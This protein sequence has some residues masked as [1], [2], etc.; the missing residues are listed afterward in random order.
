MFESFLKRTAFALALALACV[1]AASAGDS[2]APTNS[3]SDKSSDTTHDSIRA[4]LKSG[5][6]AA[7][8]E[9]QLLNFYAPRNFRPAWSGNDD[10]VAEAASVKATIAKADLQGLHA[11]DYTA[12]LAR[13]KSGRPRSGKDAAAYDVALTTALFHYASDVRTGR[14]R[15]GDAYRDVD[16]PPRF[17]DPAS[18]LTAALRDDKLGAFLQALPP[19][20]PGYRYLAEVYA[21][22]RAVAAAGGW[23][24]VPAGTTF[25]RHD[26]KI[27]VLGKRLALE[28]PTLAANAKPSSGD[29]HEAL[30]RY[31]KRNAL[32]DDGKLGPEVLKSLN[33]P[34]GA[35]ADQIA[36]NMDRWRW[37][38]RY[39]EGRY[40]E[41]DVPDQSVTFIQDGS[42]ELYSPVI[43]GKASTPTPILRTTVQTVVANPSW[44]IPVDIAARKLLPKLRQK[45][46]YLLARHMV[47]AGGPAD[48][49]HGTKIDWKHVTAA[50]LRYQIQ[51]DP[52]NDNAL[53]TI[54]FDMPNNFDVYLHDTPEKK[55][56][57]LAVREKSNGCVRVQKIADLASLVLKGDDSDAADDLEPAI[58]SG[59]TQRFKLSDPV[60]VYMVYWTAIA[61]PDGTVH[62][63]P[64]LYGRDR[65]L[66][67]KL[68]SARSAAS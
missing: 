12:A 6:V 59:Q 53:G 52:G 26:K 49:P 31:E 8:L 27:D 45:P 23:P 56:F 17:F 5:G 7:P 37:M 32:P 25:D 46:D 47:L 24:T 54:L 65:T 22:Y 40:I 13:W 61:E 35:R 33:V 68:R 3:A 34:A 41:V 28:D 18:E 48:D 36:A 4:L 43:I 21:R 50:N 60:A 39:L 20:H 44:D 62:F 51:Q 29:V 11:K 2:S 63:R 64:D 66:I 15:P 16:L 30:I 1:N 67:A 19:L 55:L 58:A 57:T 42:A 9:G 10:A 38:P 14:V